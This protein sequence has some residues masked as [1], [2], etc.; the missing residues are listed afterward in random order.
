VRIRVKRNYQF[1]PS[2]KYNRPF[3]FFFPEFFCQI[4]GLYKKAMRFTCFLL[5]SVTLAY[6]HSYKLWGNW[7]EDGEIVLDQLQR[8]FFSFSLGWYITVEQHLL[9]VPINQCLCC[10]FVIA[11]YYMFDGFTN[12]NYCTVE[13]TLRNSD[14]SLSDQ[15]ITSFIINRNVCFFLPKLLSI[16][17]TA[18]DLI[19]D[20]NK[21]SVTWLK[22]RAD[23]K[24]YSFLN[25]SIKA[26]DYQRKVCATKN[27]ISPFC[28]A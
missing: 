19:F 20:L 17:S 26:I 4:R 1:F 10:M 7:E 6:V 2:L 25:V 8:G 12:V 24:F 13:I 15:K 18:Y 14:C 22:R 28:S 11:D 27:T 5:C 21:L 9:S 23:P 3:L 16:L